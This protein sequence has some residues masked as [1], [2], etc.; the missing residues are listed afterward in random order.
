MIIR[1]LS[2]IL[3]RLDL[4]SQVRLLGILK[5]SR[6]GSSKDLRSPLYDARPR[7]E[8]VD[9]FRE[10]GSFGHP[11]MDQI[12]E[13]EI[14]KIGPYS[15]RLPFDKIRG[16][17]LEYFETPNPRGDPW[18]FEYAR[19]RL[20]RLVPARSLRPLVLDSAFGF[21]PKETNL[22]LPLLTRSKEDAVQYLRRARYINSYLQ[23]Y[24]FVLFWRGQPNGTNE[25]K[26][27]HVSGADHVDTIL[28][29]S[30]LQPMLVALRSQKGFAA[31][32]DAE[33]VDLAVTELLSNSVGMGYEIVSGDHSHFDS[34]LSMNIINT[35]FDC[36]E[37]WFESSAARTI[38]VLREEFLHT[39]IV[40][41]EG[42]WD[43]R[44]GAVMSGTGGTNMVDSLG[45]LFASWYCAARTGTELFRCEVLGDDF[46]SVWTNP[47]SDHLEELMSEI[48][49]VTNQDKQF[50]SASSCHYLQRWH[51]MEY[52][53]DGIARGV[54]SPFRA[55]NGMLSYERLRRGWNKY[56]DSA[57]WIMQGEQ[58]RWDKRFG[59]FVALL[60]KGDSVM[61][62]GVDPTDVFKLAGGS[63]VVRRV[64]GIESFPFNVKNP[65][66]VSSFAITGVLRALQ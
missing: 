60:K 9:I 38:N 64:L 36:V 53:L 65:E 17:L 18:C 51:S 2:D 14:K 54:R 15:I 5:R 44:A 42:W 46:V 28:W 21:M 20:M 45:N 30:F 52:T 34:H 1:P 49:L 24:P 8:I 33:Y 6:D 48:G 7:E 19:Q 66:G 16:G 29:E 57:R 26:Q 32:N 40:C 41:P 55:L 37:A 61:S 12:D 56:M 23:I 11:E 43:G 27:R 62:S 47:I 31:W 3:A 13:D 39:G 22:G 58:V 4:D 35:V 63:T 50:I 25:P 59:R 10:I